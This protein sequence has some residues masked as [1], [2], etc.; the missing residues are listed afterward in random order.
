MDSNSII[1]FLLDRLGDDLSDQQLELLETAIK[2]RP[3]LFAEAVREMEAQQIEVLAIEL[4]ND[5]IDELL[6]WLDVF[7]K[8]RPSA[9]NT[10]WIVSV[11][12]VLVLIGIGAAGAIFIQTPEEDGVDTIG[13]TN[14][15]TSDD[16][17]DPE[18]DDGTAEVVQTEDT[19]P[20]QDVPSSAEGHPTIPAMAISPPW[21]LLDD[22]ASRGEFDWVEQLKRLAI[23]DVF[24]GITVTPGAVDGV[25]QYY[26]LSGKFRL[27]GLRDD[28][29]SLRLR[30]SDLRSLNIAFDNPGEHLELEYESPQLRLSSYRPISP[31]AAVEAMPAGIAPRLRRMMVQE[32]VDPIIQFDWQDDP[33]IVNDTEIDSDFFAVRWTGMINIPK[34][35]KYTFHAQADDGLRLYINS[36]VVIDRWQV[37]DAF[38]ANGMVDLEAGQKQIV[39]EFFSDQGSA[40]IQLEWE[41]PELEMVRELIPASAL[42]TDETPDA[43]EG[44]A[45]LYL[46][47]ANI[48]AD[49]PDQVK[50]QTV[51]DQFLWNRTFRSTLD[52]RYQDGHLVIARGTIPLVALPMKSPPGAITLQTQSRLRHFEPI[53][54]PP[55][56]NLTSPFATTIP[57]VPRNNAAKR[58][59]KLQ[60]TDEATKA[61][62]NKN[63]D[64]TL[65]VVREEG[66]GPFRAET[67]VNLDGTTEILI[68]M[69][70]LQPNTGVGFLHPQSDMWLSYFATDVGDQSVICINPVD[71]TLT[72]TKYLDGILAD[73][74]IWWK[75][76]YADSYINISFS[77]DGE[78]WIPLHQETLNP[79]LPLRNQTSI[80]VVG[81][82]GP[83][84]RSV[85]IDS[86]L[87]INKN[88]LEQLAFALPVNEVPPIPELAERKSTA[89]S[90]DVA[91][92]PLLAKRPESI[93][94]WKWQLACYAKVLHS[95]STPLMRQDAAIRLLKHAVETH[96]DHDLLRRALLY[97]PQRMMLRRTDTL[98]HSWSNLHRM[99]D[100]YASRLWTESRVDELEKLLY[101]WYRIDVG[102]GGAE[103]NNLP[104]APPLLTMLVLFDM[105]QKGEWSEI[106]EIAREYE[107]L[108]MSETGAQTFNQPGHVWRFVRWLHGLAAGNLEDVPEVED[109]PQLMDEH[110][111]VVTT[112]R[113]SASSVSELR[114]AIESD[115]WNTALAMMTNRDAPEGVLPVDSSLTLYQD[116]S[117][118]YADQVAQNQELA[119]I[120]RT[121]NS[122]LAMLR[123]TQALDAQDSESLGAVAM[124]FPGTDGANRATTMLGD[125]ALSAGQFVEASR[126]YALALSQPGGQSNDLMAKQ[127]LAMAM[128]GR[129]STYSLS[130]PVV[131]PA[132]EQSAADYKAFID[133]LVKENAVVTPTAAAVQHNPNDRTIT[134]SLE[135]TLLPSLNGHPHRIREFTTIKD[136]SLLLIHEHGWLKA[137]HAETNAA[138]WEVKG[139]GY[140]LPTE[141][142][143]PPRPALTGD[144]IFVPMLFEKQ[145]Q[146]MMINRTSGAVEWKKPIDGMPFAD[147]IVVGKSIYA[148]VLKPDRTNYGIVDL[149]E[150]ASTDGEIL[151]SQRVLQFQI[152]TELFKTCQA[153]LA[154]NVIVLHANRAVYG[155]STTGT[156]LWTRVLPT[157]PKNTDLGIHD[158]FVVSNPIVWNE[159]IVVSS[160]GFAGVT[161]LDPR[162]GRIHW[163]QW[164]PNLRAVAGVSGDNVIVTTTHGIL[165][166][167]AETGKPSWFYGCRTRPG[168]VGVSD[169]YVVAA[170]LTPPTDATIPP[171]DKHRDVRWIHPNSGQLIHRSPIEGNETYF[172]VERCFVHGDQIIAFSNFNVSARKVQVL[173]IH[174]K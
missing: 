54:L 171:S 55:L 9:K 150:V 33:I 144:K 80:A 98:D 82:N 17:V 36:Q 131:T 152:S 127:M 45:G 47:G 70:D 100:L 34:D 2:E 117:V 97:L 160:P 5:G 14:L 25:V 13:S 107:F 169:D 156:M 71:R 69:K 106:H 111:E 143:R 149:V 96:D 93:P 130:G 23:P 86:I 43:A 75:A 28:G 35:G 105:Y 115:D 56:D 165:A 81:Y 141:Y 74:S 158:E 24:D 53:R 122:D 91:I 76:L 30:F 19:E 26:D 153:Y 7:V 22:K 92:E 145:F 95:E 48:A 1:E 163:V 154:E 126:L 27:P 16:E 140:Q 118:Y 151:S 31:P 49:M 66:A 15:S 89:A 42:R 60:Y 148:F 94:A 134:R 4:E 109:L 73:D 79:Q 21:E 102:P 59:W 161:R 128:T 50:V 29:T 62:I 136:D 168:S 65:N 121:Q 147:P 44:L 84:I 85:K 101:D 46:Y 83:G 116:A 174:P 170:M 132:G 10:G 77:N 112:D 32:R 40:G 78:R 133:T 61:A 173:R 123:L 162:T 167:N 67:V 37:G 139:D 6:E 166:I 155:V 114:Q 146:W 88:E 103:Y 125:Q 8:S 57:E 110:R 41:A 142:S 90:A 159:S 51:V 39:V 138:L 172:D 113:E 63:T 18:S 11:L 157:T 72:N 87:A 135:L 64:G 12:S 52:L 164:Q 119:D 137:I 108:S 38:E 58:G 3:N 20:Q 68:E 120:I 129:Q 124:Q 99:F 104:I